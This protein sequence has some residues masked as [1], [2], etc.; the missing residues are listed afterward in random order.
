MSTRLTPTE[1]LRR[2]GIFPDRTLG[3]NFL[4]DP[5]IIDVIERTA[6]LA[7]DD[8]VL[9][10]GPGL[11]VLTERLVEKCGVV[12]CVEIDPALVELVSKEFADRP[13]FHLYSG[14]AMKLDLAGLEPPPM[15]FVSNL[16][17]NVAAPLI[18]K[19]LESLPDLGFWCL[20]LQKEIADRLFAAPGTAAYGGISVMVQLLTEKVSS[21]PVSGAVFVPRPRVRSSLLAFRRSRRS[22]LAWE[23]FPGMRALV[24][25]CFSHRRKQLVNSLTEADPGLLPAGMRELDKK[26]RRD[27]IGDVLSDAGLP[28]GIRPQALE[29]AQYEQFAAMLL[30]RAGA[31]GA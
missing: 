20:M 8:V 6:A 4:V 21:R 12:H 19:S 27:M 26:S 17:Y 29:P 2:S 9:E 25:G 23:D 16:P 14:D 18:M 22:G 11:G 7:R 28:A 10:A 15:K 24:R 5:N 30:K 1:R 13:G 3:Q 31:L